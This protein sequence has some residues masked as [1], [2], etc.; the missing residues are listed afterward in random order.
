[1][2]SPRIPLFQRKGAAGSSDGSGSQT[3]NDSSG[4]KPGAQELDAGPPPETGDDGQ[5]D[6][7]TCP[8]CG[9]T[10]NPDD[11]APTTEAQMDNGAGDDLGAK[12]AAMMGA[13]QPQGGGQPSGGQ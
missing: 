9:C 1:M 5:G 13:G 12:I 2:T 10:F 6:M 7:V 8:E 3:S 11:A 4:G